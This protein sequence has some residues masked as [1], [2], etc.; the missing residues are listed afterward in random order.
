MEPPLSNLI[1]DRTQSDVDNKT[2]KGH[3]S[4]EDLNRI[5]RW[6][7]FLKEQLAKYGYEVN[8][9]PPPESIR[10]SGIK[11]FEY[12]GKME[13]LI[14]PL[15]TT[16][17][18]FVYGAAGSRGAGTTTEDTN[19][20]GFGA[21][22]VYDKEL[23]M[24]TILHILVGGK[25]TITNGGIVEDGATQ[26]CSGGGGGMSAVFREI[27]EI[28][29]GRYQFEKDGVFLEPLVI[30]AGG[31]GG[32]DS[33][34]QNKFLAGSHGQAKNYIHLGN[35]Q[36]YSTV[37][38]MNMG[39]GSTLGITQL[40][41]YNGAGSTRE[42]SGITVTGGYGCGSTANHSCASGG[43]WC[44]GNVSFSANS[45]CLDDTAIGYDGN[46]DGHGS[47]WIRYTDYLWN[48][49]DFPTKPEIDRIRKNIHYLRSRFY[50]FPGAFWK[51]FG[52]YR[53]NVT[54]QNA[55]DMEWD[56]DQ[57]YQWLE[58]MVKGFQLQE[59]NTI[60]MEAGGV[61]NR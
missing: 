15:T 1:Y 51:S 25:G 9:I 59:A 37:S 20:G 16:Y 29:D 14:L 52:V 56:L 8:Y 10:V 27:P 49:K 26:G 18:F 60:F 46:R 17:R 61:F 7:L 44:K 38:G 53:I 2:P 42:K 57:M 5:E 31:G 19:I 32:N 22:M 43:G 4:A 50:Y 33:V 24:G 39:A 35:F 48:R 11:D 28:I 58:A 41:R 54:W 36:P 40:I 47:V 13:T 55:N 30:A 6:T 3:W 12:S 34:Y 45:W 23:P 21:K